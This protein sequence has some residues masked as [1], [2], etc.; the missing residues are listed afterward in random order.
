M[1]LS[2][3][4]IHIAVVLTGRSIARN[5][6]ALASLI[7]FGFSFCF[8][9]AQVQVSAAPAANSAVIANAKYYTY[10][11]MEDDERTDGEGVKGAIET[12]KW[13]KKHG[14][15]ESEDAV[16][17]ILCSLDGKLGKE[18]KHTQPNIPQALEWSKIA[19][20]EINAE[21]Q[22]S[23][24][25][26]FDPMKSG[27]YGTN[28][29]SFIGYR[30]LGQG[31]PVIQANPEVAETWL[32]QAAEYASG[33]G[34][35]NRKFG[36]DSPSGPE[37]LSMSYGVD[38]QYDLGLAYLKGDVLHPDVAKGLN[39]LK[40]AAANRDS[41]AT[42]L[43]GL[44]Y[45]EGVVVSQDNSLGDELLNAAPWLYAREQVG[46]ENF[47]KGVA[48]DRAESSAL[49][50]QLAANRAQGRQ[51]MW[52]AAINGFSQSFPDAAVAAPSIQA[53][54]NQQMTQ[55][56]NKQQQIEA[57]RNF[58]QTIARV[59]RTQA[60]PPRS[61]QLAPQTPAALVGQTASAKP[62]S[63]SGNAAPP[64]CVDL[65]P[66]QLHAHRAVP[67]VAGAEESAGCEHADLPGIRVRLGSGSLCGLRRLSGREGQL[68]SR[69]IRARRHSASTARR[70]RPGRG[71]RWRL[72]R[73]A[74]SDRWNSSLFQRTSRLLRR[75][76][77]RP[78]RVRVIPGRCKRRP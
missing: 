14:A 16:S 50:A 6:L 63:N 51:D 9:E 18:E 74:G 49:F 21:N 58:Q 46:L 23:G 1:S 68:H 59:S 70:L 72:W 69:P 2:S 71:Q 54:V 53:S 5:V 56:A 66:R 45:K 27:T 37:N 44:L 36:H 57:N 30:F 48:H 33:G 7:V 77:R 42:V 67:A 34:P 32:L 10:F 64:T 31:E 39:W 20:E 4:N 62:A 11:K 78:C 29:F 19:L 25:V 75:E 13:H 26:K 24:A 55:L 40:E 43:L 28:R 52:N 17:V 41:H 65:W 76:P 38:A 61:T 60:S 35:L 12:V 22:E 73:W 3:L 8:N 15:V 47:E